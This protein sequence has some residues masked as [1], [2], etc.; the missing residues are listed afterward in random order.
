MRHVKLGSC[1]NVHGEKRKNNKS[2]CTSTG[3]VVIMDDSKFD[4][5]MSELDDKIELMSKLAVGGAPS[6]TESAPKEAVGLEK[7]ASDARIHKL[8]QKALV[9]DMDTPELEGTVEDLTA[10][11]FALPVGEAKIC[12]CCTCG[13][14]LFGHRAVSCSGSSGK[15]S[16]L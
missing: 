12:I 10:V 2:L 4:S 7:E 6:S 14:Q 9:R 5:T 13:Y 8:A 3:W 16:V 15:V 1:S 11:I